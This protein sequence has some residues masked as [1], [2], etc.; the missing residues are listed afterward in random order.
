MAVMDDRSKILFP[1]RTSLTEYLLD[2][3]LVLSS[4]IAVI[5]QIQN[6]AIPSVKQVILFFMVA[7][8]CL[9]IW[10]YFN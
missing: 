5:S 1:C 9:M 8:L 10:V 4:S 7:S 2:I 3:Y 6:R